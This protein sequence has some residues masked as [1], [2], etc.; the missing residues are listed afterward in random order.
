M[1]VK[2]LWTVCNHSYR[3]R[4]VIINKIVICRLG[5]DLNEL[6]STE[7]VAGGSKCEKKSVVPL[8]ARKYPSPFFRSSIFRNPLWST[9]L[10]EDHNIFLCDALEWTT[11]NYTAF[12]NMCTI[13]YVTLQFVVHLISLDNVTSYWRVTYS[14]FR[15]QI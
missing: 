10:L 7:D 15:Y 8:L 2:R 11:R 13:K 5:H 6:K 12:R 3:P 1:S 4:I 14:T 9:R